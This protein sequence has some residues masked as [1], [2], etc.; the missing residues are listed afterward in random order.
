MIIV[1]GGGLAGLGAGYVLTEGDIPFVL[2]EKEPSVGGLSKTVHHRGFHFDLGGHRFITDNDHINRLI[3]KILG[4]RLLRVKRRSKIYIKGKYIDYP[5]RPFNALTGLGTLNSVLMV[6]D[7]FK[8]KIRSHFSDNDDIRNLEQWVVKNFGRRI[9]E[10]Y[11]RDY[12]EKVWGM[13][14]SEISKEW[15]SQR[16]NGLSLGATLKNALLHI[17]Q[18]E[19]R[20]LTDE[21][22]YPDSGIGMIAERLKEFIQ[23]KAR[24]FTESTVV[25]MIHDGERIRELSMLTPEGIV[26]RDVEHL[27]STIPLHT[28]LGI[29][30]PSPPENVKDALKGLSYRHLI[31]VTV[32]LNKEQATDLTWL[33]FPDRAIPFGRIHEPKNWSPL[34]APEGKTHLVVEFFCSEGDGL[35][36]CS[37]DK[38]EEFTVDELQKLGFFERSEIIDLLTLRI[39]NAYPVF[40]INFRENLAVIQDYLKGFKNLSIAG[41]TGAFGYLNMDHALLSGMEAASVVLNQNW[42]REGSLEHCYLSTVR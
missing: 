22:L 34:M 27:I 7:Y 16:I 10:L 25:E 31:L 21:F 14:C 3:L 5:L 26:H 24:V 33:Y 6:A 37:N 17:R 12:S 4:D 39:R 29:M 19:M 11:F 36:N 30:K 28:L 18:K 15:I 42:D 41:R 38:L 35:W 2:V 23:Y 1:L 9:F 20:T 32:F 13:A 8:E 40:D